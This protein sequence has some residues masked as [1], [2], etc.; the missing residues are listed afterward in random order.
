VWAER[1]DGKG[2]WRT[3]LLMAERGRHADAVALL[4]AAGAR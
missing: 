4:K 1:Y 2:E 3:P